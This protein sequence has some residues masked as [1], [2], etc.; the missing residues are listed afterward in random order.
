M[1]SRIYLSIIFVLFFTSTLFSQNSS[2]KVQVSGIDE[3]VGKLS[4]GLFKDPIGFPKK[5]SNNIGITLEVTDVAMENTFSNLEK[6][7]Y[8][9][10][11]YHDENS[12]GELDRNFLGMPSE[13]YVFSNYAKGILGPPSFEEAM[14]VHLD[15]TKINLDINK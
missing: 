5:N 12:N 11:I 2:I 8:A 1:I 14:F 3:V 7:E 15:S 4:I 9:I 10:A 6:G 13:D